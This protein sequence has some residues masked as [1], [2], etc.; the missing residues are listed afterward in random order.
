MFRLVRRTSV[1][2]AYDAYQGGK[3]G[4]YKSMTT[5][6]RGRNAVLSPFHILCSKQRWKKT[7]FLN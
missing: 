3:E 2:S 5:N 4:Y 7:S 6:E 1:K